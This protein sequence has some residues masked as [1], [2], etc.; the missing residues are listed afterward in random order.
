M[1][2]KKLVRQD[3]ILGGLSIG[4]FETER[5]QN[6]IILQAILSFI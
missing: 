2:R 3:A 5:F 4:Q 6:V 1:A